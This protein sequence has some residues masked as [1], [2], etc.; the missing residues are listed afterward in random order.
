ME[1]KI[2]QVY[3]LGKDPIKEFEAHFPKIHTEGATEV[4]KVDK[5]IVITA[6]EKSSIFKTVQR[7]NTNS[8]FIHITTDTFKGINDGHSCIYKKAST[9]Q[10]YWHLIKNDKGIRITF[11]GLLVGI[12]G[13][14]IDASLKLGEMGLNWLTIN[15]TEKIFYQS[16]SFILSMGG[17]IMVF[18]RSIQDRE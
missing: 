18:F 17:L 2:K 1:W 8:D 9:L 15:K 10:Y 16:I 3:N 6:G 5:Y 12:L 14:S 7:P 4:G 11:I 13:I